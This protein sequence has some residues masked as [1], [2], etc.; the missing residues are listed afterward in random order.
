MTKQTT[1]RLPDGLADD[2]EAVARVR[3][4]SVNQLIIDAL[5]AGK[6]TKEALRCLMRRISDAAWRQLQ[7]DRTPDQTQ[8]Q[9]WPRWPSKRGDLQQYRSPDTLRMNGRPQPFKPAAV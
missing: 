8:D 9:A 6:S 3:G 2:A 4:D 1:V 7:L 5:A